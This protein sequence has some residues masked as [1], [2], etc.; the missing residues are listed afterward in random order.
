MSRK[1][2]LDG[3]SLRTAAGVMLW[4]YSMFF[5]LCGSCMESTQQLFHNRCELD[6]T[7]VGL[8]GMPISSIRW[9]PGTTWRGRQSIAGQHGDVREQQRCTHTLTHNSMDQI[10]YQSCFWTERGSQKPEYPEWE[11][12]MHRE[13]IQT[14]F[15]KTPSWGYQGTSSSKATVLPT[16]TTVQS[17]IL[18]LCSLF[19]LFVEATTS[20]AFRLAVTP[21]LRHRLSYCCQ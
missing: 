14:L 7:L 1:N 8:Q 13:N 21:S 10:T 15:R 5:C 6:I 20:L 12:H 4:L 11:P 17:T 19:L 2:R 9:G 3:K 18:T 16:V